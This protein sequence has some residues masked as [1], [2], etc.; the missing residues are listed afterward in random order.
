LYCV[1]VA[2]ITQTVVSVGDTRL[3][4]GIGLGAGTARKEA[5]VVGEEEARLTLPASGSVPVFTDQRSTPHCD[6][7]DV[8]ATSTATARRKHSLRACDIRI[9]RPA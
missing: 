4:E 1:N 9:L 2:L 6:N 8:G 5:M 7:N 3:L